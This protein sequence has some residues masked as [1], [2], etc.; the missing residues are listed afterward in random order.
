M[1]VPAFE[2][3]GSPFSIAEELSTFPCGLGGIAFSMGALA[4]EHEL[5][6][7]NNRI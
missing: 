3:K 4:N 1:I 5:S 7:V 6:T 2:E